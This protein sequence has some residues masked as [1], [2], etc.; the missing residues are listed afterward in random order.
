VTHLEKVEAE[1]RRYEHALMDFSPR[2]RHGPCE[3]D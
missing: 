3:E 1:L 2:E